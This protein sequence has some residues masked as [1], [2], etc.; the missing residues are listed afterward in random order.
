MIVNDN[1][2][3]SSN[4]VP[5]NST[6]GQILITNPANASI[7]FTT[8][9]QSST[10]QNQSDSTTERINF[11]STNNNLGKHHNDHQTITVIHNN[12]HHQNLQISRSSSSSTPSSSTI[13]PHLCQSFIIGFQDAISR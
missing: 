12:P 5:N 1:G 2:S 11:V 3:T 8:T 9:N 7:E 4:S 13:S 6:N 10:A